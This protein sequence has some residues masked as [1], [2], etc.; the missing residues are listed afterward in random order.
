MKKSSDS[1]TLEKSL[2]EIEKI[3]EKMEAGNLSL[4]VSLQLFE[5]GI[6]LTRHC[7]ELLMDA[8]Q[9]VTVLLEKNGEVT[10]KTFFDNNETTE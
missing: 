9:K 4:D 8:E 5:R 7:Q 10:D 2:A 6:S 1:P 3:V